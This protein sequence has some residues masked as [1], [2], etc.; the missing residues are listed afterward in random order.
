MGTGPF[1]L[2]DFKRDVSMTWVKN[3]NYWRKGR[4]YLDGIEVRFIPDS[5]TASAMMQAKAADMWEVTPKTR[6]TW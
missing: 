3:P 1:M 2:K 4:P 5:V 6:L